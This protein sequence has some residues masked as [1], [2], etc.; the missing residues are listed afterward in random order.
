MNSHDYN[1]E[2]WARKTIEGRQV[3]NYNYTLSGKEIKD[4]H[5]IKVVDLNESKEQVA[6]AYIFETPDNPKKEMMRVD[7][8]ETYSWRSAQ[9]NLYKHLT[10]SMRREI[11][12]GTKE[13]SKVG[14][15]NFVGRAPESDIPVFISFTKGNLFISINSV[16]DKDIN[17]S[18]IAI[19]VDEILGEIPTKSKIAKQKIRVLKPTQVVL[20]ANKETVLIKSL[21]KAAPRGAWVKIIVSDGELSRRGD[22]LI[23]VSD[24]EG[25]KQVNIFSRS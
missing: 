21:K 16:G 14:D 23:Y 6:R 10:E 15:V 25:K 24:K 9:A 17:V 13:L 19:I 22:T 3:Y 20:K 1:A 5:L 2:E 12:H 4:W 11:P 18:S 7:I 8:T